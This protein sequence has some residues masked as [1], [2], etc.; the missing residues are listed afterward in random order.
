MSCEKKIKLFNEKGYYFFKLL[1]TTNDKEEMITANVAKIDEFKKAVEQ[2]CLLREEKITYQDRCTNDYVIFY[3]AD[4]VDIEIITNLSEFVGVITGNKTREDPKSEIITSVG[5]K[6]RSNEEN[7]V[8]YR[9]HSSTDYKL[10]PALYREKN[11]NLLK[12]E[13]TLYNDFLS[14]N[15]HFFNECTTTLEK[16]VKMQHHEI[17]T[18]LLDLT[19]NPYIAL[20]FA[21]SS[22]TN[23]EKNGEVFKFEIAEDKFKYYDSDTV[24]VISNLTKCAIDFKLTDDDMLK[25]IIEFNKLPL[26]TPLAHFVK[27]DRSYFEARIEPS[28]LNNYTLVVKAKM[29]IDRIIS[30]SGAFVLFGINKEKCIMSEFDINRKGYKQ[31]VIIIPAECKSGILDELEMFNINKST[32]FCDM[33]SVAKYFTEKYS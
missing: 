7:H 6:K 12:N 2:T 14:S 30:Q 23:N 27:D 22:K 21:C 19:E 13:S 32:V 29:T 5:N 24:S 3:N 8:Y 25:D 18:R 4:K 31:K 11:I 9:G 1:D 17:P 26:I 10:E 16:L 28:H 20:Y 15:P 33:D